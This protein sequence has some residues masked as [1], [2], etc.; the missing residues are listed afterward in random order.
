MEVKCPWVREVKQI[1]ELLDIVEDPW[2][3]DRFAKILFSDVAAL[4]ELH[5]RLKELAG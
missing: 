3:Y 4:G 2:C 1:P 5:D